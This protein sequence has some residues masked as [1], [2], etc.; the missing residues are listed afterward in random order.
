M[1]LPW[2]NL[3]VWRAWGWSQ[4]R[5]PQIRSLPPLSTTPTGPQN[6]PDS[7]TKRTDGPPQKT[8]L[9]SGYRYDRE[10]A[11]GK[12]GYMCGV[13]VP[14]GTPFPFYPYGHCSLHRGI[15]FCV[16]VTDITYPIGAYK[17]LWLHSKHWIEQ[18]LGIHTL[19]DSVFSPL[20]L[21]VQL[22]SCEV[23]V[24][25]LYVIVGVHVW[26]WLCA[27]VYT[28][29]CVCVCL[30]KFDCVCA[31][32]Y[33]REREIVVAQVM[34]VFVNDA[35][36]TKAKKETT[37][38]HKQH[39]LWLRSQTDWTSWCLGWLSSYLCTL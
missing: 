23:S 29:V 10:T 21:P 19:W 16:S 18:E 31:C 37:P 2:Q 33:E 15:G 20:Q 34:R 39:R 1:F 11:L 4:E 38:S 25:V 12:L 30:R 22:L 24:C 5:S 35:R 3:P 36:P 26:V 14:N 8:L 32:V 7:T 28:L 13:W 17:T 6:A 9:E 27:C